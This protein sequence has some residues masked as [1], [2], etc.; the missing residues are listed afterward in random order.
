M[1]FQNEVNFI[2]AEMLRIT[3]VHGITKRWKAAR[4]LIFYVKYPLVPHLIFL[5]FPQP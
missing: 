1:L 2:K 4:G 3:K 5:Q